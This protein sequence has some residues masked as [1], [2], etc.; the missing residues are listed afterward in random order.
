MVL[1]I[2]HPS[3]QRDN[4]TILTNKKTVICRYR[5]HELLRR[6]ALRALHKRLPARRES[7]K[8]ILIKLKLKRR[9]DSGRR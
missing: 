5:L 2:V 1:I 6:E 9:L 8:K 7:V 3:A 4:K